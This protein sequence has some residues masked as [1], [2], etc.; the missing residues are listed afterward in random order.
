KKIVDRFPEQKGQ[1]LEL[2]SLYRRNDK[3]EEALALLEDI[4]RESGS[5][6][7]IL[8]QQKE[9]YLQLERYEEAASVL[10]QLARQEP[11]Y[12]GHFEELYDIY[13]M[14]DQPVQ[15]ASAMRS[16]LKEVP[17]TGYPNL[18][19][20][21]HFH[22]MEMPDSAKGY[23]TAAL[24]D[25]SLNYPG[26]VE[27]TRNLMEQNEPLYPLAFI[28]D[29]VKLIDEIHPQQAPVLA[30]KGKVASKAQQPDSSMKYY[31]Q[32][33]KVDP[34]QEKVWLAWMK[35]S[36]QHGTPA[37]LLEVSERALEFYPNQLEFLYYHGVARNLLNQYE[38]A[39][40]FL[41]KV[42]RVGS[43]ENGFMARVHTELGK[44][45]HFT[46][47][48]EDSDE[49]FNQAL[50]RQPDDVDVIRTYASILAERNG[51]LQEALKMSNKAMA[52]QPEDPETRGL[53]GFILFQSG[54]HQ[55]AAKLLR[56]SIEKKP[57]A[58]TYERYGD[59]LFQLGDKKEALA[60]WE[61]AQEL[62]AEID[63]NQKMQK[64]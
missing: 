10:Q 36:Y 58:V 14:Q 32:S 60:Q 59:V 42:R 51:Q 11:E 62:G 43:G 52:L 13:M 53:H 45:Y 64:P 41:N 37:Q 30:L 31:R 15:A 7:Q 26:K 40:F 39:I 21:G 9:L 23:L 56:Q 24:S 49:A 2:A 6:A 19:L 54:E 44:A 3:V 63:L 38:D 57:T 34:A 61:K 4:S 47:K 50:D 25:P 27:V 35:T 28:Q 46:K 8:N 22:Q 16:L 17:G 18:I 29:L 1:K 20:A 12:F 5:T 48:F 33:L 55:E